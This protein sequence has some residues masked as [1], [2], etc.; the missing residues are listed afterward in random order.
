MTV[1]T[2]NS[3]GVTLHPI[4]QALAQLGG[5]GRTS[6]YGMIQRGEIGTVKIGNRLFVPSDEIAAFIDRNRHHGPSAN[7]AA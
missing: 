5:I 3:L 7:D 6:L 1:T 4:P 2:P